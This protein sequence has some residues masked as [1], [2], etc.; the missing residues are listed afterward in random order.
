MFTGYLGLIESLDISGAKARVV[1]GNLKVITAICKVIKD[2]ISLYLLG[3]PADSYKEFERVMEITRPW[4]NKIVFPLSRLLGMTTAVSEREI[5]IGDLY[6]IRIGYLTQFSRRELF[7]IPFELRCNVSTKRYSI[8]GLPSL[9]L[10]S[11][12]WICW[13]ELGRPDFSQVHVARFEGNKNLRVL[14][15]GATPD[16]YGSGLTSLGTDG[17]EVLEGDNATGQAILWPVLAACSLARRYP[18]T[19]FAPEYIIPQ[20]LLQWV[21]KN[22]DIDGIRYFSTRIT[23]TGHTSHKALNFVFPVKSKRE[24]GLCPEL[25]DMFALTQPLAWPLLQSWEPRIDTG[26]MSDKSTIPLAD[27]VSA[28]YQET[29][30]YRVERKLSILTASRASSGRPTS[31]I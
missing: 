22:K 23:G 3:E 18:G 28:N 29:D 13:E 16:I 7:H 21:R 27:G 10:G 15:F 11:S 26:I 30:F 17:V 14:D 5:S 31:R 19:P 1:R 6:R 9:Y 4:I 2:C 8:P 12:L 25:E 24:T 20:F